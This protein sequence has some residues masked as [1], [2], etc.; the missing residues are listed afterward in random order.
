MMLLAVAVL[1]QQITE[2]RLYPLLQ[3]VEHHLVQT[4]ATTVMV[5]KE[6]VFQDSLTITL[7]LQVT[8]FLLLVA[9]VA[10]DLP[11]LVKETLAALVEEQQLK[12][13]KLLTKD[14]LMQVRAVLHL[15]VVQTY[16]QDLETQPLQH[17]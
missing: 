14:L 11:V 15:L 5:V 9:A 2:F 3:V 8:Q 10:V 12:T 17:N 6:E 7:T 13:V 4:L 16:Q 1:T